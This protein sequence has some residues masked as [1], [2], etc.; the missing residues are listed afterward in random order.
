[1]FKKVKNKIVALLVNAP[2]AARKVYGSLFLALLVMGANL[3]H[4]CHDGSN[5]SENPKE[6][7]AL[8]GVGNGRVR[9]RENAHSKKH[10][11]AKQK[12]SQS[13][14]E[15]NDACQGEGSDEE[16]AE[17]KDVEQEESAS[18]EV[19]N[20]L[21]E[22]Q[23]STECGKC[24]QPFKAN[25]K[26]VYELATCGCKYAY[27]Y[28]CVQG[29]TTSDVVCPS[30]CTLVPAGRT[31]G[32]DFAK[33]ILDDEKVIS[34]AVSDGHGVGQHGQSN[35]NVSQDSS[36][37]KREKESYFLEVAKYLLQEEKNKRNA[38]VQKL[39]NA[40][41]NHAYVTCCSPDGLLG[42]MCYVSDELGLFSSSYT[43]NV[44]D[45]CSQ[46]IST[47][48]VRAITTEINQAYAKIYQ[49]DGNLVTERKKAFKNHIA[50]K[51]KIDLI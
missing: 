13:S 15:E 44:A 7:D 11:P 5:R 33:N 41:S 23:L 30:K 49:N 34:L 2:R 14:A 32:A 40:L 36:V 48:N 9:K 1:M 17:D 29:L 47:C 27:H 6:G 28:Q 4:Q 3:N 10:G 38:T 21:K 50:D 16:E 35:T 8:H 45:F 18:S 12:P 46:E 20:T 22:K 37:A 51:L 42:A 26:E 43:F 24:T 31:N 19:L 39:L 25:D